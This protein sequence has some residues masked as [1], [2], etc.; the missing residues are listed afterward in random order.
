[1]TRT[2]TTYHKTNMLGDQPVEPRSPNC[3]TH[4]LARGCDVA[5]DNLAIIR[6]EWRLGGDGDWHETRSIIVARIVRSEGIPINGD[7]R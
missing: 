2:L 7:V 3:E 4:E 6:V 1:M 5:G